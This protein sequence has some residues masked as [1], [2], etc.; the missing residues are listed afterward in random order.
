MTGRDRAIAKRTA[1]KLTPGL[2]K[3]FQGY[4][5][6]DNAK[7]FRISLAAA[8][9]DAAGGEM[10][11]IFGPVSAAELMRDAADRMEAG[12]RVRVVQ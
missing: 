8:M 10:C 2:R 6:D 12:A 1:A 5:D 9:I 3:L 11:T 7:L 4:G